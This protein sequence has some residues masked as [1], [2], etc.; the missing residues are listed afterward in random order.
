MKQPNGAKL[1]QSKNACRLI[2]DAKPQYAQN[3]PSANM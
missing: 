1:N 2:V 3:N